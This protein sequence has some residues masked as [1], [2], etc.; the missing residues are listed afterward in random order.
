M[1]PAWAISTPGRSTKLSERSAK[2]PRGGAPAP[3][4][5]TFGEIHRSGGSHSIGT[6]TSGHVPPTASIAATAPPAWRPPS[7]ATSAVSAPC[8]R[9]PAAKTPARE[10]RSAAST[11]GPRVPESMLSPP[12]TASSWSGI[13]SPVNTTVS[14]SIREPSLNATAS[15]RFC[16]TISTTSTPV[17]IGTR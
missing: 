11:R 4:T 12:I 10:V 13:Q 15:T 9:L 16:P 17:L 8:S 1:R 6:R 2:R 7:A 3:I 5:T 14:H